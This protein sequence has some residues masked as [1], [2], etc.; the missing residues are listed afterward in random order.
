MS[1]RTYLLAFGAFAVGTSGY[2]VSGVLPAVSRELDVSISTAGQLGTAFAIAYAISSPLLAA[3]TGRWERRRLLVVALVVSTIGN[4]LAVVAPSY[5][6]L[7]GS[8]IIAAFG[9]AIYTPAATVIATALNPPERRGR[10]VAMV[11]GGLTFALIIGVPAGNLLSGPLGYHGVFALVAAVSLA[12]AVVVRAGV[13]AVEAPPAVGLRERFAV[14]RDPRV[15]LMLG[16][17]VLG[18]L[19]AMAVFTYVAPFLSA[20]AGARGTAVSFLLLG[21]GIGATLGNSLGGRAADR[22]GSVPPLFV[23]VGAAIVL[24][25]T[26]PVTATSVPAA[27][28][29]MFVW[30]MFTWSFNPPAQNYFIGL[31]PANSGLLLSLNA[32]AIYLGVGLSGV[33]GGLVISGVGIRALPPVAGIAALGALVLLFFVSRPVREVAVEDGGQDRDVPELARG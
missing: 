33:F 11:F 21:Y 32:S 16:V 10:A 27:A 14:A 7:L 12:G 23:S 19:S 3:F 18:V 29:V 4:A 15:R 13:P 26:L 31:S 25:A 2:I 8:R 24:L 22:F 5:E 6:L 20:T 17:T 30:G 9:A 1:P 28:V